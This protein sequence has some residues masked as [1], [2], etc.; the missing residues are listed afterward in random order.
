TSGQHSLSAL[1]MVGPEILKGKT[2]LDLA[3]PLDFSK[4]MP[5]TLT[6]CNTDSLGE[7]IQAAFPKSNVV[8][9]LNT[10]NFGLMVHPSMVPGN[11]NL[12]VSGNDENAKNKVIELLSQLGWQK[13]QIIDLGDIKTARGTEMMMPF[14]LSLMNKFE[15]PIFNINIAKS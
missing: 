5:P 8:K 11:H 9:S 13:Q 12:F 1:N 4:G 15:S 2:I 3:N 7:Q 10:V 14:W 6:I